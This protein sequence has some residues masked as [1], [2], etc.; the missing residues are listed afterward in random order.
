MMM[1]FT[2]KRF[3]WNKAQTIAWFGNRGKGL[4]PS[5]IK[6][7]M[8]GL[9]TDGDIVD[10]PCIAVAIKTGDYDDTTEGELDLYEINSSCYELYDSIP[11]TAVQP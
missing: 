10:Q 3:G 8:T 5:Q 7:H 6:R 11:R 2:R 4:K 1:K 9:L